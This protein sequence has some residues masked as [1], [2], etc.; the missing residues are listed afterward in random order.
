MSAMT[1]AEVMAFRGRIM[2]QRFVRPSDREGVRHSL[3]DTAIELAPEML[4]RAVPF[5]WS[6]ACVGLAGSYNLPKHVVAEQSTLLP[7]STMFWIMDGG[8][9][10]IISGHAQSIADGSPMHLDPVFRPVGKVDGDGLKQMGVG[11]VHVLWG[12]FSRDNDWEGGWGPLEIWPTGLSFPDQ[13]E[14]HGY[15]SERI[16]S[17][18]A[19]LSFAQS[20]WVNLRRAK[21]RSEASSSRLAK[22]HVVVEEPE[23]IVVSLRAPVPDVRPSEAGSAVQWRHRWLVRGHHRAQ[24]YPSLGAH[25]VV[26]IAPHLKGPAEAPLKPQIYAVVR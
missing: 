8:Q 19:M 13:Y 21:A 18:L 16:G 7:F 20:R 11:Q 14:E 5:Y 23:I 15:R 6:A 1:P 3:L 4:R 12:W 2:R 26:W 24:W 17:V 25:K 9:V 10:A 22:R